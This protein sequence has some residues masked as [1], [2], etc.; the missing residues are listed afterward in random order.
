[1]RWFKLALMLLMI[2]TI[3]F[4]GNLVVNV[5]GLICPSCAI[6]IKKHLAKTKKVDT[7]KLDVDKQLVFIAELK[8]KTLTDKEI[9]TA[10][11]NAG[12]EIGKGG[13]K[14]ES[15]KSDK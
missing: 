13:I 8:G 7:V 1:M 15:L 4:G 11:E 9:R 5:N 3:L 2:P 12:Y 14:R 10:I 6:G